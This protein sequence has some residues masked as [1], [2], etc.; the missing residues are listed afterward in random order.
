MTALSVSIVIVSRHRAQALQR[1]LTGVA[2]LA[3]PS[4]EIVVVADPDGIAAAREW[5]G[6]RP[7]KTISF[8]EP[9]ISTARNLGVAEAAGEIIAFIDDDAVPEP[10]W[11]HH[12]IA[13][14]TD[15]EVAASGG[16]V[17]GRNGISLQWAAHSVDSTGTASPIQIA[18]DRPVILHPMPD[19]AIKTEGTNMAIRRDVLAELGGFDPAFHYYLDETDLNLRLA[20]SGR[21]TAIV[22]LAQVHHGFLPNRQRSGTRVPRDL[23]D[24]GA[25]LA[26]FLNKHCAPDR[27]A[28]ILKSAAQDQRKRLISHMIDGPIGPDTLR[29]LMRRFKTGFGDG[30]TRQ[31]GLFVQLPR[32][33][34]GFS[35]FPSN[36][37]PDHVTLSGRV[38]SRRI[39]RE[40]AKQLASQGK[41]VSLYL[42]SPTALFHHA[43][44]CQDGY[45][46]QTGGLF[47]RS[48]RHQPLFRLTTFSRRLKAEQNRV[49]PVRGSN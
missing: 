31:A 38:W 48:E 4:F 17:I 33:A 23:F 35:T 16:Y 40:Q 5:A 15:P 28:K 30:A 29:R 18:D 20:K 22:P 47:G 37:A 14:F 9:N 43:R 44:Y 27:H 12:L 25:S 26:V 34:H 49:A 1:C 11:L 36:S 19:R 8:D 6:D 21:A 2:Q 24:Q 39:L 13:P 32:A 41:I 45:W 46:E 3:Y 7:L 10:L 42:F